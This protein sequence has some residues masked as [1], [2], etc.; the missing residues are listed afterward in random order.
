MLSDRHKTVEVT[1]YYTLQDG[2]TPNA[3]RELAVPLETQVIAT[4]K[5]FL[6]DGSPA[7]YI[8]DQIPLTY[9]APEIQTTLKKGQEFS[10]SDSIFA[11]S[12]LWPG[13]EIDHALVEISPAIMPADGSIPLSLTPGTPY[14]MLI[15]THYTAMGE[16]VAYS[17][18]HVDDSFVRFHVV[19]HQ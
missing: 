19:R 6:A 4:S 8:K 5:T 1:G 10:Y 18:I 7:I 2:T 17:E 12:S 16:P 9:A 14:I 13:R 3:A 15:E 11:F